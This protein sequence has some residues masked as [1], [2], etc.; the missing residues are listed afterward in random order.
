MQGGVESF[1]KIFDA[2]KYYHPNLK[3]VMTYKTFWEIDVYL[4]DEL[5]MK[6]K[7]TDTSMLFGNASVKLLDY[8][9][10]LKK[11]GMV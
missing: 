3:M 2:M 10:E 5:I 8:F 4:G 7:G 9:K 1:F 6:N 11:N